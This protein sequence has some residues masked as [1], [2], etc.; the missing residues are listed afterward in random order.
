MDE[1]LGGERSDYEFDNVQNVKQESNIDQEV[2]LCLT[3][4]QFHL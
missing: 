3:C 1:N 2:C 4:I